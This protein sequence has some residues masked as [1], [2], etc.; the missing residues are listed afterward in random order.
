MIFTEEEAEADSFLG[1]SPTSSASSTPFSYFQPTSSASSSAF[2]PFSQVQQP[3]LSQAPPTSSYGAPFSQPLAQSTPAH[4][5]DMAPPVSSYSGPPPS[6]TGSSY[7]S[8]SLDAM[9]AP[10]QGRIYCKNE[11]ISRLANYFIFYKIQTTILS[12]LKFKHSF[13]HNKLCDKVKFHKIENT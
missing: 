2:D 8:P 6:T 4:S 1:Q 13:M 9:S 3:D 10:P 12:F 7:S 11:K 5:F